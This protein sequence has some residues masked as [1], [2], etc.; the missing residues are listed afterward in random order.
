MSAF[1][2][3]TRNLRNPLTGF[4]EVTS[5]PRESNVGFHHG[6]DSLF[7]SPDIAKVCTG[8]LMGWGTVDGLTLYQP[9]AQA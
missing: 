7:G 2:T 6:T 3:S 5:R 4:F 8:N 1:R 9:P